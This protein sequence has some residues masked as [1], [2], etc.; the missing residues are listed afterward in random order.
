MMLRLQFWKRTDL[1][2]R[3][4]QAFIRDHV[5]ICSK[6]VWNDTTIKLYSES[7][8]G[9]LNDLLHILTNLGVVSPILLLILLLLLLRPGAVVSGADPY[10]GKLWAYSPETCEAWRWRGITIFKVTLMMIPQQPEVPE[11]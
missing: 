10:N 2:W 7:L 8:F 11:P 3:T 9:N 1:Q 5:C 4:V 6:F